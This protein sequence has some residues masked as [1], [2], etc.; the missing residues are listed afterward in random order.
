MAATP[1]PRAHAP[2]R[3]DLTTLVLYAVAAAQLLPGV[4]AFVAPGAFYDL[5]GPYPPQNDHFVKDLGSWQIALG[6]AALV[7]ARRASWR[8]PMLAVLAVQYGLHTVSHAIDVGG[9][10]PAW[11]GPVTLALQALITLVLVVRL[12][13]EHRS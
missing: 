3:A 4:L 7:A 10:D 2:A 13:K 12:A 5:L 9:T 11:N 6:A 1:A 8:A